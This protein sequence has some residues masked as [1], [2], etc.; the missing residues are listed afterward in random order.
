MKIFISWSGGRSKETAESFHNWIKKV[1][2]AVDPFISSNMDKGIRWNDV[3]NINL[4]E[5]KV[6]IFFLDKDNIHSLQYILFEAGAIAKTKDAIACTFLLDLKP[7]DVAPPLSQ[8]QATTFSKKDIKKL[9]ETIN[10]KVFE[11]KENGLLESDL[12]EAFETYYPKL[13][14]K[15]NEIKKKNLSK[16]KVERSERELLEEILGILR[17]EINR[18]EWNFEHV[19]PINHL[20]KSSTNFNIVPYSQFT[21]KELDN[22][23]FICVTKN[24]DDENYKEISKENFDL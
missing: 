20:S 4:E 12:D 15:L 6:G 23:P 24:K 16:K 1:I 11:S 3:L 8:F 14:T 22:L 18:N 17:K 7:S 10:K 5:I 2:Q 19:T 9:V 21:K 13:E